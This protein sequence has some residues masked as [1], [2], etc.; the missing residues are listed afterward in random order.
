MLQAFND[1]AENMGQRELFV[2]G[3]NMS[4]HWLYRMEKREGTS[5]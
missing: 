1:T 3:E 5:F 2:G 4:W